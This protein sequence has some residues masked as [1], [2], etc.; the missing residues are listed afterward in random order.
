MVHE[1]N[2]TMVNP[3]DLLSDK[4]QVY[5]VGSRKLVNAFEYEK[6]HEKSIPQTRGKTM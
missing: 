3:E 4:V 5:D 6:N 2:A 1:I